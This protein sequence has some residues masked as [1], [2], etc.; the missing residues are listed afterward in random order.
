MWRQA[1]HYTATKRLPTRGRREID[2]RAADALRA[3]WRAK[4]SSP[5]DWL[6]L[7]EVEEKRE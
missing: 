7:G 3:H 2:S 1:L 6:G 5:E 4:I